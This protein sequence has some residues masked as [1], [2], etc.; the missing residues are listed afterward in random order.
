MSEVPDPIPLRPPAHPQQDGV[1]PGTPQ[2]PASPV[3]PAPTPESDSEGFQADAPF[4]LKLRPRA[5]APMPPLEGVPPQTSPAT[6]TPRIR[7]KPKL[8]SEPEGQAEPSDAPASDTPATDQPRGTE[9][10]IPPTAGFEQVSKGAAGIAKTVPPFL[11]A[12][13]IPAAPR[14]PANP[15]LVVGPSR[16]PHIKG[17]DGSVELP[18]PSAQVDPVQRKGFKIGLAVVG[19]VLVLAVLVGGVILWKILFPT[20]PPIVAKPPKPA[21]TAKAAGSSGIA[22]A[23]SVATTTLSSINQ[24][25]TLIR[26]TQ[27]TEQSRVDALAEGKEPPSLPT[28]QQ[29][30]RSTPA[31]APAA[32]PPSPR[33]QTPAPAPAAVVPAP[34]KTPPP[35]AAPAEAVREER[36]PQASAAFRRFVTNAS[37]PGVFQGTPARAL[38]NGCTVQVGELANRELGIVFVRIDARKKTITFRDDTGAEVTRGY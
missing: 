27:Q 25:Q 30:L 5:P 9:A 35:S 1:L 12:P 24:M 7:L 32:R 3:P 6:P 14:S 2:A 18:D 29:M 10:T 20:P 37:I 16:L 28:P 31:S 11:V 8:T 34:A 17:P 36:P 13:S 23:S 33:V 26:D 15:P 19:T 22:Q 4:R 38:I 21:A